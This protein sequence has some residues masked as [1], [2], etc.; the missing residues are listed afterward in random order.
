MRITKRFER[1]E[2]ERE[3]NHLFHECHEIGSRK[4]GTGWLKANSLAVNAAIECKVDYADPQMK[5]LLSLLALKFLNQMEVTDE[6]DGIAEK[7]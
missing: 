4:H 7:K 3:M 1:Q 6:H 5:A 2:L